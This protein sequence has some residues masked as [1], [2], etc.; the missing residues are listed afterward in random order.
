METGEIV[1]LPSYKLPAQICPIS[2]TTTIGGSLYTAEEDMNGLERELVMELTALD[3]IRWWH[4]NISK[5]EF[6]INGFI[7]HYPDIMIKT[8]K[9]NLVLAETKGDHLK[10]DDSRQKVELGRAWQ[11]AANEHGKKY[12]YYMVFRDTDPTVNGAVNMSHFLE[13]LKR[14]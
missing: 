1:C 2:Y 6:R 5:Q 3:N 12:Y 10:N 8:Q 7:N 4:R 9:G 14:L 11:N 13:I